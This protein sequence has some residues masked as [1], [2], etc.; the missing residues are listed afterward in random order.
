MS[1]DDE[2]SRD[3]EVSVMRG[4]SVRSNDVSVFRDM[5]CVVVWCLMWCVHS[6]VA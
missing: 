6:M 3:G 2:V 4:G 5:P 1:R